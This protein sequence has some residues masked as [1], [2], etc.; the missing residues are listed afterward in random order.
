MALHCLDEYAPGTTI[1]KLI[2]RESAGMYVISLHVRPP[3]ETDAGSLHA[4][5]D[6]LLHALER[7]AGLIIRRLDIIVDSVGSTP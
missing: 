6:S 2:A 1:T 7:Q 3:R 5:R 4:L